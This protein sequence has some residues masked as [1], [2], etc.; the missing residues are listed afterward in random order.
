MR[1]KSVF[2][3]YCIS[4]HK[5]FT[6]N[7]ATYL[8][9]VLAQ[10]INQLALIQ[11]PDEKGKGLLHLV[12]TH[13]HLPI[14]A[15][16]HAIQIAVLARLEQE[17]VVLLGKGLGRGAERLGALLVVLGV[18]LGHVTWGGLGGCARAHL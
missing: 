3:L 10:I 18:G 9:L 14:A 1:I 7:A 5:S 8:M 11:V 4:S 12:T 17:H 13:H 16:Q 6:T 15:H 2:W